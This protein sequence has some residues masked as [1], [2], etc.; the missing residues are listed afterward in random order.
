MMAI[1]R[2]DPRY[3]DPFPK[4]QVRVVETLKD[5]VWVS[6]R[7]GLSIKTILQEKN[8]VND[9]GLPLVAYIN[10]KES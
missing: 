9:Q 10:L 3:F 2:D 1:Q 5:V 6:N 8:R 4:N 7:T